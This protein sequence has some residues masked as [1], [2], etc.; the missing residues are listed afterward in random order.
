MGT[1]ADTARA[2]APGP[3]RGHAARYAPASTPYDVVSLA[4]RAPSVHNTQ[5][6]RWGVVGTR[7][8]L[9]ADRSRALAAA[10]PSG[11]NLVLSCGAALHHAQVA[12]RALGWEPRVQRFP[13]PGD[14]DLLARIDLVPSAPG[15][16]GDPGEAGAAAG[17][18]LDLRALQERRTDRRRFTSWPVPPERLA[19]LAAAAVEHGALSEAV[20]DV[21]ARFRVE[22]LVSRAMNTQEHDER[23]LAEQRAWID[24]SRVDG[25]PS[26]SVPEVGFASPHR[27]TRFGPPERPDQPDRSG[28]PRDLVEASDGVLVVGGPDDTPAS[29]LRSG[30]ALS[31]LWLLATRT[32]LSVVPLSQVVEVDETRHSLA[33]DVLGSRLTPHVAL[34]IGW[35]EISRSTHC[36]TP[37]RPLRDVLVP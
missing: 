26:T 20:V 12:A 31:A 15:D 37:R 13:E 4:C 2:T 8:E 36:A 35:Q 1:L 6:W 3:A 25:I 21:A 32:G 9:Y 33:H 29:W 28:P 19:N 23:L 24:H 16:P 18:A 17:A 10:D 22:L 30:E 5:P 27:R 14:P 11:R 7:I 34:R